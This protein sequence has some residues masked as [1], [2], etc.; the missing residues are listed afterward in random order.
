M[1]TPLLGFAPS[2]AND[3]FFFFFFLK[4]IRVLDTLNN[5]MLNIHSSGNL[6]YKYHRPFLFKLRKILNT[7]DKQPQA[8]LK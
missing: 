6:D 3:G 5:Q 4:N 7:V 2:N 1:S 8:I